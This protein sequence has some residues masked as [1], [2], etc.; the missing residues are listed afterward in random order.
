MSTFIDVH[1]VEREFIPNSILQKEVLGAFALRKLFR[2]EELK[3]K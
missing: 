2:D 3:W 1:G